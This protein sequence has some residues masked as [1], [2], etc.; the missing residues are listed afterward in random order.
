MK[1]IFFKKKFKSEECLIFLDIGFERTSSIILKNSKFN[2]FRSIPLGGNNI[3]KDISKVL[4]LNLDYSEDLKIR[5]NKYLL[6]GQCLALISRF[7][8]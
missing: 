1:T 7:L 6:V 4:N 3:T 5:F 8:N 2:F